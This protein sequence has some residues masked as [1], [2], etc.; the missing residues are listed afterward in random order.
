MIDMEIISIV[1]GHVHWTVFTFKVSVHPLLDPHGD[2]ITFTVF[3]T[4][5]VLVLPLRS[6]PHSPIGRWVG[7]KG[8]IISICQIIIVRLS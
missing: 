6:K 2:R 1:V 7:V 8:L 3:A 4:N 5:N